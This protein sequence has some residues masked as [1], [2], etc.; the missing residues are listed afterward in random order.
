VHQQK[1]FGPT[2]TTESEDTSSRAR[3]FYRLHRELIEETGLTANLWLCGTV[4]VDTGE[5]PGIGIYVLTG[6]CPDGL[7]RPSA[8]GGPE[9]VSFS[10]VSKLPTVEDLP[11]FL[12]CIQKMKCG[13]PPFSARSYYDD[14]QKLTLEF[15]N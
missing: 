13:D 4:V 12:N 8:E 7:P 14:E 1:G 9:W 10:N 6:E 5:N 15:A 3:I 11:L 2:S